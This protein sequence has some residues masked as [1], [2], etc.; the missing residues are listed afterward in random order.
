MFDWWLDVIW[1]KSHRN[2]TYCIDFNFV[3]RVLNPPVSAK[4]D[5]LTGPPS[6]WS[7]ISLVPFSLVGSAHWSPSHWS[8][9]HWSPNS[10]VP[11]YIIGA[12]W[13]PISLVPLFISHPIIGQ[14]QWPP[15]SLVPHLIGPPIFFF[16][17]LNNI[18]PGSSHPSI[19]RGARPL[20]GDLPTTAPSSLTFEFWKLFPTLLYCLW[21]YFQ[22]KC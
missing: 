17:N 13:S 12:H 16:F 18:S 15:I 2:A 5:P 7:P 14:S 22:V 8:P 10:L 9:S 6:H 20:T 4:R 1:P 11:Q 3:I 21:L 19:Q